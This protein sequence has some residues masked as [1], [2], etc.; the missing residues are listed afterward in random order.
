[1]LAGWCAIA[2]AVLTVT[3][4]VTPLAFFGA[5]SRSNFSAVSTQ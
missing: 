1:M 2:A 4:L 3:G 5:G